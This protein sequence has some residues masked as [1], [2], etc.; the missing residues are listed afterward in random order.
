MP[1]QA[2]F[3]GIIAAFAALVLELSLPIFGLLLSE[4]SLLFLFFTASIEE[5]IKYTFI[6][7]H[8]LKL[9]L[10]EKIF[11]NAFFIGFGFALIDILLKQLTAKGTF[12]PIAGIFLV[13]LLSTTLLGLFFWK[14]NQRSVFLG[15]ILL[16]LNIILH[17]GYNFLI[18]R[19]L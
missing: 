10:K 5:I 11:L 14:K 2:F 3:E 6:Y 1:F 12:W 15:I 18:L 17:F 13:H 9:E 19:Y 16:G 4:T 7:N 8:Y